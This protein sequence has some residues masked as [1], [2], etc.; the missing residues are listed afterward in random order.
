MLSPESTYCRKILRPLLFPVL[1]GLL[2]LGGVSAQGANT[3]YS[4][5]SFITVDNPSATIAGSEAPATI[6]PENFVGDVRE[7]FLW[8]I[9]N[10]TMS[11]DDRLYPQLFSYCPAYRQ[12]ADPSHQL[13][14]LSS[15]FDNVADLSL[16]IVATVVFLN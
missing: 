10:D 9:T 6:S 5:L 16:K 15:S 2:V 8:G 7:L 3:D 14:G 4:R 13:G 1:V 12:S 11:E